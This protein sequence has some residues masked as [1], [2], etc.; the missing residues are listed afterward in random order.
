MHTPEERQALIAIIRA[1]PDA[2][3]ATVAG[4]TD[5]QLDTIP[6][7]MEWSARQIVHHVADSH[8]NA[9]IRTK[10]ALTETH[11]TIAP[12]DQDAW[13]ALPDTLALPID[14]SLSILQNLHVR[15][16]H[17]LASLTD[18]QFSNSY[19]HPGYER[20]FTLDDLLDVY[21]EH[22]QIH[23][24]QILNNRAVAGW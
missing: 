7:P 1:L 4:W 19:Y 16:T 24:D 20:T 14:L 11:P 8:M 12:Y 3:T 15:F 9:F 18:E 2:L 6:A 22:G 10:L 13:A 17:L 21:S 23:I 5:E